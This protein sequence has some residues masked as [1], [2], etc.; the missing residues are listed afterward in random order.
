MTTTAAIDLDTRA[1]VLAFARAG[2]TAAQTAEVDKL[3][4]A[5]AWASMHSVESMDDAATWPGTE[6]ELAL[7]GP[8][9]PLVAEFAVAELAVAL[10]GSADAARG[11]LGEAME[12]RYRLPKLWTRVLDGRVVPW[13]A[14]QV[15]KHTIALC[16]EAAEFVDTH[17]A[18]FAHAIG[19]AALERLIEEAV[20]RFMPAEAKRR[21][22]V[23]AEDRHFDIETHQVSYD[24][25]VQ[26][27]G[28]LDLADALDLDDAIVRGAASLKDLGCEESLDVRRS[29][30]VG[31]LARRQLSLDLNSDDHVERNPQ[32]A[33]IKPRQVVLYVHLSEAAIAGAGADLDL[34]RVEKTRSFVDADQVRE[35]CANPDTSVTV[36]PV[37]DLN[38]QVRTDAYEIPDR[39]RERIVLRDAHCVFPG[40]TR[41]ARHADIDHI[42]P[43]ADGGET[44]DR[45]LAPLC[46]SHHR[47][48]THGGWTYTAIEPGTYL[49]RS[50]MGQHALVTGAGTTYLDHPEHRRP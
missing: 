34:A 24:G 11:F 8:G 42:T 13:R 44:T 15:A 16:A 47:H 33:R 31:D 50:P 9:A 27:D 39:L 4:A 10:G 7:A 6:G 46:R 30:A 32:P 3:K 40:C 25:T 19:Y 49:W 21:R 26:V 17:V 28:V 20:V 5:V 12:L 43:H 1:G 41:P 45:N 29:I 14:R 37:I 23:A 22:R 2:A 48:K 35:W 36:R 18:A 38:G